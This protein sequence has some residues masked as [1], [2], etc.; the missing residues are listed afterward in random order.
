[1]T[2]QQENPVHDR[3]TCGGPAK[4][5]YCS[6][7]KDVINVCKAIALKQENIPII[8]Q[9]MSV[10]DEWAISF[11]VGGS[12]NPAYLVITPRDIPVRLINYQFHKKY[13]FVQGEKPGEFS[14]VV[15]R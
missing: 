5:P 1:M 3:E 12:E 11:I 9:T 4:C 2:E 13:R 10:T 15:P 7:P 14:E 6:P 8:A